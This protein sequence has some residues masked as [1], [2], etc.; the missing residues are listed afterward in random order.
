MEQNS[1]QRKQKDDLQIENKVQNTY[2]VIQDFKFHSGITYRFKPTFISRQKLPNCCII[3]RGC[4]YPKTGYE[5]YSYLDYNNQTQLKIT[6]KIKIKTPVALGCSPPH[7]IPAIHSPTQLDWRDTP[8]RGTLG[9]IRIGTPKPRLQ[10]PLS[11]P[12]PPQGLMSTRKGSN[13]YQQIMSLLC[14]HYIT[15]AYLLGKGGIEPPSMV[16][17]TTI[18]PL[19]YFP[20]WDGRNRTYT[21]GFKVHCPTFRPHPQGVPPKELWARSDSNRYKR[22]ST[23]L[24]SGDLPID[25]RTP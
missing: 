11:L 1:S 24:Q 7:K 17:K 3:C 5:L 20:Y 15:G 19:N 25:P 22:L 8:W 2:N 21:H 18:L 6:H 23:D 13:L 16:P 14:C 10:R 12:I 9:R 4:I